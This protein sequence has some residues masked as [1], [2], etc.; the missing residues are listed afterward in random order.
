[1]DTIISKSSEEGRS[2]QTTAEL[3]PLW[4]ADENE[5]GLPF[6]RGSATVSRLLL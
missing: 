4:E 3:K 2:A 1:M 6:I 5:A